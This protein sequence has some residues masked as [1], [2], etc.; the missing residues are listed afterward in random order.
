MAW[1]SVQ[2]LL[3]L[4]GAIA[5]VS[6]QIVQASLSADVKNNPNQLYHG[7]T[8]SSVDNEVESLFGDVSFYAAFEPS[9]L[10]NQKNHGNEVEEVFR[11]ALQAQHS[12]FLSS[13][14]EAAGVFGG[15][16]AR[17]GSVRG[18]GASR[19]EPAIPG[20]EQ[21][22]LDQALKITKSNKPPNPAEKNA[23]GLKSSKSG[24]IMEKG[25]KYKQYKK[26]KRGKEEKR[27]IGHKLT[28]S[29]KKDEKFSYDPYDADDDTYPLN[30]DAF[31]DAWSW[32]WVQEDNSA[33]SSQAYYQDTT[34]STAGDSFISEE[35]SFGGMKGWRAGPINTAE[36]EKMMGRADPVMGR[37]DFGEERSVDG[38]Q[39]S[40]TSESSQPSAVGAKPETASSQLK[41]PAI[42]HMVFSGPV[43]LKAHSTTD[44]I[45]M[46]PEIFAVLQSVLTPYLQ[47][48]M[49]PTLHAYTLEVEYSPSHDK[50]LDAG[51]VETL[52]EVR[53]AFKVISDSVES[54][55]RIDHVQAS[56]WIHDYFAEAEIYKL[57]TALRSANIPINDITFVNQ[58]FEVTPTVAEAN[59]QMASGKTPISKSSEKASGGAM[60]GITL[61][62]IMVGTI[63]F[64]HYTGRLPSKA[65]VG[66]FSL[67]ARD[68]IAQHGATARY[69]ISKHG[70]L[71]RKSISK[72]FPSS[73]KRSNDNE[74]E[75]GRRRTY[76]GTFRR[77][78][79]GG[80][81][82]AKLQ[83]KPARSEQYLKDNASTT[84]SAVSSAGGI[85]RSC[86]K[87]PSFN[88]M[89]DQDDYSFSNFDGDY[90]PSAYAPSTPSRRSVARDDVSVTDTLGYD[91]TLLGRVSKTVS[92]AA[93]LMTPGSTRVPESP[94]TPIPSSAPRRITAADIASPRDMDN[95]S[96]RSFETKTPTRR[97][98]SN[99]PFYREWNS[100]GP[101]LRMQRPD[102]KGTEESP[103][104]KTLSIPRFGAPKK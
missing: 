34:Q 27:E 35:S 29:G 23:K 42:Q 84:S 11:R 85:P 40:D 26:D 77:H 91:E 81:Q 64:L 20:K 74:V 89:L 24:K 82:K 15:T 63:F 50:S 13:H 59:S 44:V 66:E 49:G 90:E 22:N 33:Q 73:A 36:S 71:A 67:T 65:Q 45:S 104:R 72:R 7:R 12:S 31:F 51:S 79:T 96:V 18:S 92:Q 98:P 80:L 87:S 43:Y 14:L 30:D 68:S 47:K 83:K 4:V 1:R 102:G 21:A 97:S 100:S 69:S 48:T 3:F 9:P 41:F 55:K 86:K 38:M 53:C 76:S 57:L 10:V 39:Q 70:K 56:R 5:S 75:G 95:W 103:S 8:K 2:F 37:M 101:G 62:V 28:K 94:R 32:E 16:G 52:M 61:S 25:F 88:D 60:V 93:Y 6:S 17:R 54:F 99:H 58:D 78:P 46:D 19:V